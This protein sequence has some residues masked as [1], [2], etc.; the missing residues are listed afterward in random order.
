MG[1]RPIRYYKVAF[2][3]VVAFGDGVTPIATDLC[4]GLLM[5]LF[6]AN[7]SSPRHRKAQ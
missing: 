6:L 7:D 2:G 4:A 3:D 1:P 5:L